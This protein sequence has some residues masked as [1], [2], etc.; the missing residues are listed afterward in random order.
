MEPDSQWQLRK[1][2]RSLEVW[3]LSAS[4]HDACFS[5]AQVCC[6]WRRQCGQIEFNRG[7][8]A[9]LARAVTVVQRNVHSKFTE[10][11]TTIGVEFFRKICELPPAHSCHLQF[12]QTMCEACFYASTFGRN[13]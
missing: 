5:S 2:K 9:V 3:N 11:Q 13:N 8:F 1:T 10:Q 6:S 4:F 12:S 7:L